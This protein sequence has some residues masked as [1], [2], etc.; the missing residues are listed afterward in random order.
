[1]CAS[2]GSDR[3]RERGH[4]CLG[5]GGMAVAILSC[6]G[7]VFPGVAGVSSLPVTETSRENGGLARDL[8]CLLRFKKQFDEVWLSIS[9]YPNAGFPRDASPINL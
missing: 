1:M 6:V 7:N 4:A 9:F 5:A 3:G 2:T 8:A